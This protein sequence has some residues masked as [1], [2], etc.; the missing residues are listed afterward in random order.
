ML[1]GAKLRDQPLNDVGNIRHIRFI[2]LHI[3]WE[4]R[5]DNNDVL[6][7]IAEEITA[8]LQIALCEIARINSQMLAA[9]RNV[10]ITIQKGH[11][12]KEHLGNDSWVFTI[13]EFNSKET[14]DIQL[15]YGYLGALFKALIGS[16][17]NF[18]RQELNSFY[19]REMLQRNKFGEKALEG[20]AYQRVF[21]NSI[22]IHILP[23]PH[24]ASFKSMPEGTVTIIYTPYLVEQVDKGVIEPSANVK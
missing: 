18:S 7:P 1:L 14:K 23:A 8:F 11:F 2:A 12:Q 24:R 19:I 5:F 22:G 10:T 21:R 15:H 4:I 20:S 13:P 9:G 17:T 6:T 16:L 3:G